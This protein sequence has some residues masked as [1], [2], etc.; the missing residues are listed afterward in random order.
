MGRLADNYSQRHT[1]GQ[2][3]PVGDK[4]RYGELVFNGQTVD[5][6]NQRLTQVQLVDLHKKLL[7]NHPE[8]YVPKF[9]ALP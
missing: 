4:L 9:G 1:N 5:G 2:R 3:L 6:S 7:V 8:L